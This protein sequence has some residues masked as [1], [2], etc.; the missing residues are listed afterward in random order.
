MTP[1]RDGLETGII[2]FAIAFTIFAVMGWP[3]LPLGPTLACLPLMVQ[4]SF[5]R[6]YQGVSNKILGAHYSN[7]GVGPI[8]LLNM[9]IG[10]NHPAIV[11]E[12]PQIW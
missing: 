10:V 6:V 4:Y 5:T 1:S 3:T 11:R 7:R 2:I 9:C 12:I 8:I